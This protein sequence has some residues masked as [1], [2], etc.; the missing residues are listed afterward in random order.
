MPS[1]FAW[2]AAVLWLLAFADEVESAT[3]R[4]KV[5][6]LG[7]GYAGM[8]VAKTLSDNGVDDFIVLEAQERAGG[9][10]LSGSLQGLPAEYL[11]GRVDTRE[12]VSDP[13]RDLFDSCNLAHSPL[14]YSRYQ[15]VNDRGVN[16]TIEASQAEKR[17]SNSVSQLK[18]AWKNGVFEGQ[19]DMSVRAALR[20]Y[21]W[22]AKSPVEWAVEFYW[23]QLETVDQLAAMSAKEYLWL[24]EFY[25]TQQYIK[26]GN[27]F[28]GIQKMTECFKNTFASGQYSD[29]LR[30]NS[31]VREIQYSDDSVTVTLEDGSVYIAEYAVVT[32]SLGVLQHD[33]VTFTPQLP[34]WKRMAITRFYMAPLGVVY[35]YYEPKARRQLSS[36]N[37]FVS[38]DRGRYHWSVE[39]TQ[40]IENTLQHSQPYDLFMTWVF[41]DDAFRVEGQPLNQTQQEVAELFRKHY[42]PS[43]PEPRG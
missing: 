10:M 11:W 7:G 5:V 39:I 16:V 12:S 14:D 20:L 29:R 24:S 34:L 17:L 1:V 13:L 40:V 41:D 37:M 43:F 3:T 28:E 8:Q 23:F 31:L 30:V 18:A 15:A 26:S 21:G 9:R 2:Y 42:G 33:D 22:I 27:S 25:K 4:T 36:R 38:D 19:D 6:I 32:F 35:A